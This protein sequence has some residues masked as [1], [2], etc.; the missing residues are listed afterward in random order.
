ML[1]AEYAKL[2]KEKRL[3]YGG[4]KEHR[5]EMIDLKMAKQIVDMFLGEPRQQALRR[6]RE[7]SL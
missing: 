3:L 1:N 4:Y 5:G 6:S 7:H 2:E